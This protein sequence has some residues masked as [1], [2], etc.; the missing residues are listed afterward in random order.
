MPERYRKDIREAARS[1]LD[2]TGKSA[3][4]AMQ[5]VGT[6]TVGGLQVEEVYFES[7]VDLPVPGLAFHP[8]GEGPASRDYLCA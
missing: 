2:Y 8:P 3:A 1:V 4:G 6:R 7:E 5:T